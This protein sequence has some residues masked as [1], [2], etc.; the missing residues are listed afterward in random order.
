MNELMQTLRQ[1]WDLMRI[2]RI[3]MGSYILVT[4]IGEGHWFFTPFGAFFLY[5]AVANIGCAA[6]TVHESVG[7]KDSVI[8][9]EVMD[10]EYDEVLNTK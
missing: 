1:P 2:L 4:S 3:I 10:V 7:Q 5:Q 6:C 8:E 9:K